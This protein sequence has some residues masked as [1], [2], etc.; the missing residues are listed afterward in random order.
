MAM[1]PPRA[2][3]VSDAGRRS[4]ARVR[5]RMEQERMAGIKVRDLRDDLSFGSIIEGV[6]YDTLA[7]QAVREEI[8]DTFERRG[9]IVFKEVEPSAQMH[10]AISN[11]FGP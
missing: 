5:T 3:S 7:D 9:M 4:E 10:L 2:Y 11:V 6:S 8:N 1:V